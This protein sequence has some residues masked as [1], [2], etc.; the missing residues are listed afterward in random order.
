MQ[1]NFNMSYMKTCAV[2]KEHNM[3]FHF[4]EIALDG[5]IVATEESF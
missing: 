1:T 2:L 5:N 4:E 3:E